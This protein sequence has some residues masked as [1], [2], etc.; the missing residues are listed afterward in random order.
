MPEISIGFRSS[1]KNIFKEELFSQLAIILSPYPP[2][3]TLTH[4]NWYQDPLSAVSHLHTFSR[5][6]TY[7][8]SVP[9]PRHTPIAKVQVAGPKASGILFHLHSLGVDGKGTLTE[10]PIGGEK[11]QRRPER[12]REICVRRRRT[13]KRILG[14][15][16]LKWIVAS[17]GIVACS[18]NDMRSVERE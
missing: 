3:F 14:R 8:R 1:L 6:L 16:Q 9:Q 13:K 2:G 11:T 5:Y 7:L 18:R 17:V 12:K 10:E 4:I 15:W